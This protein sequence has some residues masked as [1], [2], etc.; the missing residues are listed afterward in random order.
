MSKIIDRPKCRRCDCF[1][2]SDGVCIALTSS[3]FNGKACPFFKTD[4]QIATENYKAA[5]RIQRLYGV[6]IKTFRERKILT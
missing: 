4:Q 3:K 5:E 1:A 2:N 6:D